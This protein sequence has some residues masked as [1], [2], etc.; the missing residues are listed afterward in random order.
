M[1]HL[2]IALDRLAAL[3]K[4]VKA[5]EAHEHKTAEAKPETVKA[6]VKPAGKPTPPA[7]VS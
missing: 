4:R 5:L 1:S 6:D 3:E 7:K 2:E